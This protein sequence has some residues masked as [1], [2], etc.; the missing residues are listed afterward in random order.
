MIDSFIVH[1]TV[2]HRLRE[3]PLGPAVDH[4]AQTL[5]AQGYAAAT[6]RIGVVA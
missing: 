1:P 5:Q 3:G 6:I 4:I 2:R